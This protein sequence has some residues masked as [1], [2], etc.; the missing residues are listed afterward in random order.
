MKLSDISRQFLLGVHRD[1]E[2]TSLGSFTHN[3]PNQLVFIN[4]E[5][6]LALL[7]KK[8]NISCV[9]IKENLIPY[10]PENIGIGISEDPEKSY[11]DLHN[12]LAKNTDFYWKDFQNE[13][14]ENSIIHPTAY[15]AEKNVKIGDG[16]VIGPKVC[17]LEKTIMES[18]VTIGPGCIIGGE[19]F[20]FLHYQEHVTPVIHAGGVLI[21]D[22]VEIQSNTCVDKGVYG[23]FTE[24]GNGTKID[25]LVHV[26]H[27]AKIGKFCLIVASAMI[28][29]STRIGD[30]VWIGPNASVS[31]NLVI[32]DNVWISL[33]AV[34]TKDVEKD[35]KIS[36]NFAI[37]HDKFIAFIKSIR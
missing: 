35:Q 17:I 16:C 9:V 14:S 30:H 12:Y 26:G 28:G 18:N 37:D 3:S 4:D 22:D 10:I 7:L 27:N 23:N 15:I 8:K 1:G 36:G 21:H 25:N 31:D 13:I 19:G 29:G 32:G 2:F 24:I 34:V 33:G 11:Y 20:R 5:K 6:F